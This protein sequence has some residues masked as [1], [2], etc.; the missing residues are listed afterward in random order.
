MIKRMETKAYKSKKMLVLI[1]SV[2]Q[3]VRKILNVI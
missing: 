3:R 2:T 1:H